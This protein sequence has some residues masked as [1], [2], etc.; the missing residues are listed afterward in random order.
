MGRLKRLRAK[1]QTTA[2]LLQSGAIRDTVVGR[3]VRISRRAVVRGDVTLGDGCEIHDFAFLDAEGGSIRLGS[4]CSVNPFT[5]LYG[6][7]GLTIGDN[8]RIATHVVIIPADHVFEDLSEPIRKQGLRRRGIVIEDDVWIG[9]NVVITDG[10]RI[11]TGSV[12]AAGA[13]VTQ[14]VEPLSVVGGVPA[15]VIKKREEL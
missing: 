13:V 1:L 5:V 4:H 14:N 6:H 9:A 11:G 2:S 7:G 8:V 12:V 3:N 15:R 10:V